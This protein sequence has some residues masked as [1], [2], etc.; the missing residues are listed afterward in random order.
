MLTGVTYVSKD[1]GLN[2]LVKQ[3]GEKAGL[4]DILG[5]NPLPDAFDVRVF[6]ADSTGGI[7]RR[8]F[9]TCLISSVSITDRGLLRN[10]WRPP[11]SLP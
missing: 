6:N 7:S 1:E 3:L 10:Y 11:G 9:L 8:G 5:E 2:R 4:V